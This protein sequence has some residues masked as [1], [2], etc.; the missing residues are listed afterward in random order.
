MKRVFLS[1]ALA[2]AFAAGCAGPQSGATRTPAYGDGLKDGC[3]S[4]EAS[5]SIFSRYTKDARRFE[6]D[7]QYAQGWSDG[8]AKCEAEQFRRNTAGG[9]R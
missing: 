2:L 1:V 6:S 4:G 8:F 7:P 5:I 3:N 9:S